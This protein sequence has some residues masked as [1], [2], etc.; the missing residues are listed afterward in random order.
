MAGRARQATLAREEDIVTRPNRQD[1]GQSRREF[2]AGACHA[3][4]GVALAALAAACS[5]GGGSPTSPS[6]GGG[7]G[8]GGG[9]AGSL[10]TV[11]GQ[12][13]A[14]GVQVQA[15]TGPLASVGGR[16]LVQSPQG[17]FLLART[18]EAAFTALTAICTH[19]QC[20][21]TGLDGA[22]FVC[23][24]HG[25]RYNGSGQ[26]VTGPALQA[27]QTFATAFDNGVVTIQV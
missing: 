17:S 18:G 10:T 3:V 6:E 1:D 15:G 26:V 19:E 9:G 2:C 4:S 20:T 14:G 5:G 7:G 23:P 22:I 8:G 21:I 13:V 24:C 27:L 25:S 12:A 16:A 11:T